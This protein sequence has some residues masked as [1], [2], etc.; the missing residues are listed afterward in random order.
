MSGFS[1]ISSFARS[2]K[3]NL[4]YMKS[5]FWK[6]SGGK[7]ELFKR[8]F[9]CLMDSAELSFTEKIAWLWKVTG[10]V[11]P[12]WIAGTFFISSLAFSYSSF[13]YKIA[14]F[15]FKASTIAVSLNIYNAF[16]LF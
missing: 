6:V 1:A 11:Q 4:Q 5:K 3:K 2:K 10:S 8:K 16:Y 7:N 9:S 14:A 13:K 15:K 12:S